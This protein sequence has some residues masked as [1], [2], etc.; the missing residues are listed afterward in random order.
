MSQHELSLVDGKEVFNASSPPLKVWI[1]AAG[2]QLCPENP[3]WLTSEFQPDAIWS[4]SD[5]PS[6]STLDFLKGRATQPTA[7]NYLIDVKMPAELL[8]FR[9]SLAVT[10]VGINHR[11]YSIFVNGREYLTRNSESSKYNS[12][13]I[14]ID[15][16][17]S[18]NRIGIYAK[19][20]PGEV[21]L[22]SYAAAL[23]GP[24]SRLTEVYNLSD[25]NDNMYNLVLA[26][27]TGA[28]CVLFALQFSVRVPVP[29]SLAFIGYS[30]AVTMENVI[31]TPIFRDDM[32][33]HTVVA[34]Y[35]FCQLAAMLC[36]VFFVLR[37]TR[38][39]SLERRFAIVS[40]GIV[41]IFALLVWDATFTNRIYSLANLVATSV[42]L[43]MGAIAIAFMLSLRRLILDIRGGRDLPRVRASSIL[44][45]VF[46]I[47]LMASGIDYLVLPSA[48]FER[49][50]IYDLSVFLYLGVV[51][52]ARSS[53]QVQKIAAQSQE[54][55][56][57]GASAAL[58]SAMQ[59]LAH[60]I[61]HP[62][63]ELKR[64]AERSGMAKT[65]SAIQRNVVH[66][67]SM[68]NNVLSVNA[69]ETLQLAP[70]HIA[71]LIANCAADV[72]EG[73]R[74]FEVTANLVKPVVAIDEFRFRRLLDNLLVNALEATG[75]DDRIV[76]SLS[77]AD[78][79]EVAVSIFNSGSYIHPED[80]RRIFDPRFTKGK[81]SGS[82]LGLAIVQK[83]VQMHGGRI[84]VISEIGSGT[85]FILHF[86]QRQ[87]A[88]VAAP[89]LHVHVVE[90]D[91]YLLQ[92]LTSLLAHPFELHASP[93]AFLASWMELS[94]PERR[95]VVTDY[96][97]AD[98]RLTGI[99]V[100]KAVRKRGGCCY[101]L[102]NL[103]LIAND[104]RQE[105]DRVYGKDQLTELADEL[106]KAMGN[107]D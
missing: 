30:A 65:L 87:A 55:A 54:L 56:R 52:A 7:V 49:R 10:L 76:I 93:E 33:F 37:F 38:Q 78:S 47:Y 79:E 39:D 43:K 90:D 13:V 100:A 68:L 99:D 58:G 106:R 104:V 32:G 15:S 8:N 81:A 34:S 82:G 95:L 17:R 89:H 94:H 62:L 16:Q 51:L 14:R 88:A 97:F 11:Q 80:R 5:F 107:R 59:I 85:T 29:G 60:D 61:R 77:D 67:E 103:R 46:A 92:E 75:P 84:D 83:Y 53:W 63:A 18:S 73:R 98:S 23:I 24:E 12:A 27:A 31:K 45:G 2:D 40:S 36:L 70:T 21:G 69:S 35:Y 4:T 41:V 86:P 66:I 44:T 72:L 105:F 48:G 1:R 26:L 20:S 25:R 28:I 74:S 19:L 6:T 71:K 102:T 57:L 91:P 9:E 64:N 42:W 3:C 22:A 96:F 50:M 101:L